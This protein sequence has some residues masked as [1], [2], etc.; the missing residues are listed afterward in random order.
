M[1]V[2]NYHS[3]TCH[4]LENSEEAMESPLEP[5]VFLV[6]AN[7]TTIQPPTYEKGQIPIFQEGNWIVITDLRGTYYSISNQQQIINYDPTTAPE[8]Y[9]NQVPPTIPAGQEL[10]WSN[11][12]WVLSPI[13]TPPVLTPTQKLANAGLTV[14]EL[15]SLL[16]LST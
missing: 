5:G 4:Y 14:D 10:S 3:E 8:G 6:P 9:T 2:Y 11:N 16:G 15:K 13:P 1:L 7:A 12:A